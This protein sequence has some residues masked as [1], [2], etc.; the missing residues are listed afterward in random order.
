[1]EILDYTPVPK[2]FRFMT[3]Q[4]WKL[5]FKINDVTGAVNLNNSDITAIITSPQGSKTYLTKSDGISVSTD[6]KFFVLKKDWTSLTT[7]QNDNVMMNPSL[8][9]LPKGTLTLQVFITD[10]TGTDTTP[11]FMYIDVVDIPSD[12]SEYRMNA[13]TTIEVTLNDGVLIG[14]GVQPISDRI[15]W[16]RVGFRIDVRYIGESTWTEWAN[17]S[18]INKGDTGLSA[19]E[20]AVSQGF[21][22]TVSEWLT[23]LKVK[24]GRFIGLYNATTNS[25]ALSATP[26]QGVLD[27]DFYRI[28]NGGT[29]PFAGQNFTANTVCY[30]GDMIGKIGNQWFLLKYGYGQM[31]TKVT[32]AG[33]SATQA[34][35]SATTATQKAAEAT[36]KAADAATQ[37]AQ[38]LASA[39]SAAAVAQGQATDRPSVRPIFS[40]DFANSRFLDNRFEF[41]RNSVATY[42]GKEGLIRLAN[43]N[44]PRF[45]FDPATCESLGFVHEEQR[46]NLIPDSENIQTWS[47]DN[48]TYNGTTTLL[49]WQAYSFTLTSA[50]SAVWKVMPV[51]VGT[52]YT[53]SY[54]SNCPVSAAI[55]VETLARTIQV[56]S[57][58][59]A[60]DVW[61]HSVTFTAM[62]GETFVVLHIGIVDTANATFVVSCP[63][64][65]I[66]S[67]YTSYI[68][69]TNAPVTR[70]KDNI[71]ISGDNYSRTFPLFQKGTIVV[72]G[73]KK[74]SNWGQYFVL[75]GAASTGGIN[76]IEC[77]SNGLSASVAIKKDG[78]LIASANANNIASDFIAAIAYEKNN[79][80]G[81]I[82]GN[83]SLKQSPGELPVLQ[84]LGIGLDNSPN[85]PIK[86]L[87]IYGCILS[88]VELQ[89]ITTKNR[90]S[91][92]GAKS[93]PAN[94]D[95]GSASYLDTYQILR[96]KSRQE[97]SLDCTG[98]SQ[99]RN[100]RRN[101]DFTYEVVDSTGVTI[102]TAPSAT[103]TAN[104]DY[105][106]VINGAVG[107]TFTYAIT[108]I[109]EY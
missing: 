24:D 41:S 93:L 5:T 6:G 83:L 55:R 108:P 30:E 86:F 98:A 106:L 58:V 37:A 64:L 91:G 74:K 101:Y 92:K 104:T 43:A 10:E 75:Q 76:Q 13:N 82:D 90:L 102:T 27:G 70:Y 38:A 71:Q 100:I 7:D 39:N 36:Q 85:A 23:S 50:N 22:G 40:A 11:I 60:K 9:I 16:R 80:I 28:S 88:D 3:G 45:A 35:A 105:P 79:V 21:V 47:R 18:S 96:S 46:T 56:T 52:T 65:E 89:A 29:I 4:T 63:Q 62:Q 26:A 42:I 61:L 97:F 66:G 78:A 67:F 72:A 34:A 95:L 77:T 81:A 51:S 12:S 68:P 2:R 54:I 87:S 1:M 84:K 103:C 19:Y 69:T 57:E 20:L 32:E 44:Q 99:T 48:A 14:V 8:Q 17:F 25:P 109:F 15:E 59:L 33:T 107:K 73:K 49:G 94:S 53:Y 31:M